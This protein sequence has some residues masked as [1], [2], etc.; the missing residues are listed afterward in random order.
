[1]KVILGT[2]HREKTPGK[3]SPDGLFREYKYSR[4][5][6]LEV[7]KELTKKGV[8]CIIDF[9]DDDIPGIVTDSQ[10]LV[11]RVNFVNEICKKEGSKNCIYVSVHNNAAP[12]NDNKWH[13]AT[14]LSVFVS[15]NCSENSKRLAKTLYDEGA[16][17]GLKGNRCV[18]KEHYWV[19]NFYVCKHTAC[20]AVLTENLFQDSKSDV[21][22]LTSDE[23]RKKIVKYLVDGI[24]KYINQK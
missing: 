9:I 6:C 23:G 4:E 5:I 17:L 1:M 11:K 21:A 19:Y 7:Q 16:A 18:P 8:D 22:F 13:D 15:S 14:G 2:A 20:P 12:P 3:C 24:I 10:E